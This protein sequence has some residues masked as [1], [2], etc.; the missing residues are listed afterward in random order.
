MQDFGILF[1]LD[2]T[3]LNTDELIH[4]SFK[5]VFKNLKPNYVLEEKE[6]ISFLGPPL[7]NSLSKHFQ[8]EELEKAYDLY[9]EFNQTKH[10][11]YVSI[12]EGVIS[13]LDELI[14]M[15]YP[16]AIVSTKMTK[17][18]YIGLTTF[19]LTSYFNVVIGGSDIVNPKPDPEGI[20]LALKLL[21]VNQG[22]YIGDNPSDIKAG[23]NAKIY[24]AGVGWSPKIKELEKE[25]PDLILKKMT[26]L[27]TWIKEIR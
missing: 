6:L 3:V 14:N 4:Q 7:R 16:L 19:D 11:E 27:I 5:Y 2:G 1:D 24:T 23:K 17:V 25:Q 10:K 21:G 8:G 20:N 9:Q 15:G 12:Y 13:C 22:V 26:D 18:V